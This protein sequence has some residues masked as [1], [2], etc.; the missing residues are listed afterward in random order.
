MSF[1]NGL[2]SLKVMG[3]L[4]TATLLFLIAGLLALGSNSV[5]A[6]QATK[7]VFVRN[8]NIWVAYSNGT[9]AQQ[10]TFSGQDRQPALSADG[11][12][13]AFTSGRAKDSGFGQIFL[14]LA[15]GGDLKPFRPQGMAG[16]ENP[17]FAPDGLSLVFVGLSNLI[18]QKGRE[19]EQARA[20][21]SVS[22][23]ELKS[24]QVRQIK[25]H[26]HTNLDF[27]YIYEAPVMS[28]DGHLVAYQQSGSDVS[29]GFEVVNLKGE[30]LFRLPAD[31][32]E[33]TPYWRPR[34]SP[35]GKEILCYSPATME[36]QADFIFLVDVATQ[37]KRQ[38]T[39]GARPTF[40]EEG[41]AIVFERRP[42]EY[43]LLGEERS[44]ADLWR[45]ELT[46]GAVAQKIIN[47]G[48]QPAGQ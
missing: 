47:D 41:R 27:G 17:A 24:G 11:R 42:P 40:V 13:V 46:P 29:G 32:Q 44:R 26:P 45:L 5:V 28:A 25:K 39:E 20:T 9:G 48:A 34:F 6:A 35:D 43:K 8:G 18:V 23:A 1:G 31:P 33:G 21:M 10:L 2:L 4:A 19:D 7:L 38:I 22:L 15:G 36:G 30:R 3:K 16:A 12:W 14:M 37:E